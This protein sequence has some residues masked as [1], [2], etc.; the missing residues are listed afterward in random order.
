MKMTGAFAFGLA[1]AL[2]LTARAEEKAAPSIEGKY[3]LQSGKK[4]GANPDEKA[5]KADYKIDKDTITIHHNDVKFVMSYKI[6]ASAKPMKIDMEI[7][8]GPEGIK[9]S[10]ALGIVEKNGDELKLAYSLEKEKR[11][12]DF[13][14]KDGMAFVLKKAK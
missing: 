13:D 11:P 7:I 6:D 10:K 14:G 3:T 1:V 4:F 2:S 8:E 9:G 5:M 12:A